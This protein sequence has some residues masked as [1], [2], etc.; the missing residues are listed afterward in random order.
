MT[1]SHAKRFDVM[2]RGFLLGNCRWRYCRFAH[3]ESQLEAKP[4]QHDFKTQPCEKSDCVL[5][6]CKFSLCCKRIHESERRELKDGKL[7]FYDDTVSS[8]IP[9]CYFV[10]PY[11]QM[12]HVRRSLPNPPLLKRELSGAEKDPFP[13]LTRVSASPLKTSPL[14][15]SPPHTVTS[16]TPK[17][18]SF[19]DTTPTSSP[20]E[21][22]AKALPRLAPQRKQPEKVVEKPTE[23]ASMTASMTAS[24]ANEEAPKMSP[25]ARR[26][27]SVPRPDT[28]D[29]SGSEREEEEE[30]SNGKEKEEKKLVARDYSSKE[31]RNSKDSIEDIFKLGVTNIYAC[32]MDQLRKIAIRILLLSL[33]KEPSFFSVSRLELLSALCIDMDPQRCFVQKQPDA[34]TIFD[35]NQKVLQSDSRYMHNESQM[36]LHAALREEIIYCC[37]IQSNMSGI[38]TVPG[39]PS[40]QNS[41]WISRKLSQLTSK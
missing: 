24:P 10:V 35:F 8:K 3:G 4:Y 23:M 20:H 15:T 41:E 11:E 9:F 40:S 29:G 25:L 34:T 30:E 33:G 36:H 6:N 12:G 5:N 13:A 7:Y 38:T 26:S 16:P 31:L 14:K 17:R 32:K 19:K 2:C 22:K 39:K 1:E 37:C 27:S 21:V 28:W 18:V